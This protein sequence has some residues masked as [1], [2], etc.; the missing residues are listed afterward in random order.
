M[1]LASGTIVLEQ[2]FSLKASELV[3]PELDLKAVLILDGPH[4]VATPSV[5]Q[6]AGVRFEAKDLHL[7]SYCEVDLGEVARLQLLQPCR[8]VRPHPAILRASVGDNAP[9]PPC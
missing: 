9:L 2:V 3:R 6:L 5:Q 7:V 1:G 8:K 4:D